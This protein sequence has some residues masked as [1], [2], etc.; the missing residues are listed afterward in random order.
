MNT[1]VK[2]DALSEF[3]A[4]YL[5]P[6]PGAVHRVEVLVSVFI[7]NNKN[8]YSEIGKMRLK[9]DSKVENKIKMT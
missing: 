7:N 8:K 5:C 9:K 1:E 3:F 6:T 4:L 2:L